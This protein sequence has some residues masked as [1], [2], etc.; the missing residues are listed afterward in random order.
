MHGRPLTPKHKTILAIRCAFTRS[1]RVSTRPRFNWSPAN[2]AVAFLPEFA[3]LP[4]GQ[5]G[6]IQI[7][8]WMKLDLPVPARTGT[9]TSDNTDFPA[10]LGLKAV[11]FVQPE[12]LIEL[13]G[14]VSIKNPE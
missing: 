13:I 12:E 2:R 5:P 8:A 9:N 14:L 7:P 3:S 11:S 10:E 6:P 1:T 4:S